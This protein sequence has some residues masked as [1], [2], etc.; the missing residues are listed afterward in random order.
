ILRT[1]FNESELNITDQLIELEINDF[2]DGSIIQE[3]L[4]EAFDL[5][6][7]PLIRAKLFVLSETE[8]VFTVVMHH[9][10]SD[11]W[12]ID[13]IFDEIISIY[14]TIVD[15][16]EINWQKP[17]LEYADFAQWQRNLL[18]GN[19]LAER[20]SYWQEKLAGLE[21]LELPLDHQR[22][23]V[24][25][26][27]GADCLISIE[28]QVFKALE[29]VASSS[30]STLYMLYLT[31]LKITLSRY[32]GKAGIAVGSPVSG[33]HYPDVEN[34]I[35][36]FVNTLVLRT[37]VDS[38][39][40]F[41]TNLT[42]VRS[43]CLDAFE[44]QDLPFEQLLET[45]NIERDTSRTPL[46]QVMYDLTTDDPSD[47][48]QL[49]GCE[50]EH[51]RGETHSAKFEL[52]LNIRQTAEL[53]ECRFN[54]NT[55]L[56]DSTT[57]EKLA[58]GFQQLLVEVSQ[59]A[60]AP[61]NTLSFFDQKKLYSQIDNWNETTHPYPSDKTVLDLFEEQVAKAPNAIALTFADEHLTYGELN[62]RADTLA[63]KLM[64]ELKD[65]EGDRLVGLYTERSLEMLIAIWGIMKAGAA[66]VPLDTDWPLGRVNKV[67]EN[68]GLK[69]VLTQ[70]ISEEKLSACPANIYALDGTW[71]DEVPAEKMVLKKAV[72]TDLIY[73]IFTS[74]STGEPKGV[75]LEHAG[76]VNQIHWLSQ[77]YGF[78][79]SDVTLQ[80]TPY[81]FDISILEFFPSLISGGRLVIAKPEGHKDNVYLAELIETE[82]VNLIHFVPSMLQSFTRSLAD[83]DFQIQQLKTL[84]LVF[85]CGEAL[86]SSQA[87]EV[88]KL[89]PYAELHNLYG[90]A[91]ASADVSYF[92]CRD[93]EEEGVVSIGK[94]MRNT[95][96]YILDDQL[97]PCPIGVIGELHIS[98]VCLARGYMQRADL[99]DERFINNPFSNEASYERLYKTGDLVR[100]ETDGNISFIGRKDFQ[101][102]LRGLRIE[103]GEIEA[104]LNAH[105]D[106]TQ[107]VAEVCSEQLIVFYQSKSQLNDALLKDYLAEI[108]P[109]YM[110]PEHFV[111]VEDFEKTIS[112]KINRLALPEVGGLTQEYVAAQG[113]I[114]LQLA[115]IWQDI[116]EVEKV[117]RFD[118]FFKLGGHSLK[119]TR[120]CSAIRKTLEVEVPL[121]KV[122]EKP[123][124]ADLADFISQQHKSGP[125]QAIPVV[126][127]QQPQPLSFFQQRLWLTEKLH[128]G[129]GSSYNMPLQLNLSGKLQQSE[130]ETAIAAL[131][132]RHASLR[133]RFIEEGE[134]VKQFIDGDFAFV[135]HSED[136]SEDELE[137]LLQAEARTAF[138]LTA[139]LLFR[140]KLY[141]LSPQ[142]HVLSFVQH[143]I[144]SD[145]WSIEIM[146][147][148][149]FEIFNANRE[150]RQ[151][152]L[153][154]LPCQYID[155]AVWQK[156]QL[157]GEE[158]ERK[159]SFWKDT[160]Q[161]AE[162]LYLGGLVQENKASKKVAV[163]QLTLDE[164][165]SAEINK[166][167]QQEQVSLFMLMNASL[168]LVLWRYSGK[169]DILLTSP[170]A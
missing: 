167:C 71:I 109:T 67:I 160:L 80:K 63:R 168:N 103:L 69:T 32:S 22:P 141:R 57:I 102:K 76:I 150:K 42:R 158:L 4:A 54:Y 151:P 93:M 85:A 145:A 133:T 17:A 60:S 19:L 137:D 113:E 142:E 55:D 101:V 152:R 104:L 79:V 119:V 84:R 108:L 140:V 68:S 11:G 66:Y 2:I 50:Y 31:A 48:T 143:H 132:Q 52:S 65:V 62:E 1:S 161:G 138:D 77:H 83:G 126:D 146:A 30:E 6:Q 162:A 20:K 36:L 139:D 147:Q 29:S 106:I 41:V 12:S 122:F 90:P 7:A 127:Y 82:E 118:D 61:V 155:Y 136:V 14:N 153:D 169:K 56:F 125:Y 164:T 156:E 74:G 27:N 34:M 95:K 107:T 97:Q 46:F 135:L 81:T 51:L 78:E 96:L 18:S 148:E 70:N 47:I 116:L 53:C 26:R 94:A 163:A 64:V 3:E 87:H 149:F 170:V 23:E 165:L 43:T 120:L 59:V 134:D 129:P 37:Q 154:V 40:S 111:F 28:T 35:G 131:I 5:S 38:R 21:S 89:I 105:D 72:P 9:I 10:I 114:E 112:G 8:H 45:L 86:P 100:L 44:H 128:D 16:G 98:G 15:G 49:K 33:R 121:K 25:S 157:Q 117:G 24:L 110:L 159:L 58:A 166:L 99:T 75:M 115:A 13:I 73:V 91:E 39:E 130:V 144:I 88:A 92:D 123:V 124:L